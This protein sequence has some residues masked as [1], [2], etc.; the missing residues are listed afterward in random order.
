MGRID[1]GELL[2]DGKV[3]VSAPSASWTG[4]PYATTSLLAWVRAAL[5]DTC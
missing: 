4:W 1:V 2:T 3:C 5:V